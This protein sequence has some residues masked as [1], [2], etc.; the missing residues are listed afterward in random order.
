MTSLARTRL[1]EERR[2]FLADH[3]HGFYAKP[4]KKAD[5]STDLLNWVCGIPGKA[6]VRGGVGG[7]CAACV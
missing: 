4:Q 1:L 3:P 2:A 6:G 5:G 7:K